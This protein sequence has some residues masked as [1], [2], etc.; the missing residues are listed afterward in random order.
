MDFGLIISNI[1]YW[2]VLVSGLAAM[3]LGGLW[4]SPAFLGNLWM[5]EAKLTEEDMKNA[6]PAKAMTSA[7][8]LTLIMAFNLAIFLSGPA[9]FIW[10]MTVGALAGIGWV[11]LSTGINYL[12]EGKSFKLFLING[13]YQA[14]SF[15]IMGGII[16]GWK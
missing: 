1:N 9:D 6:S 11:A 13:G 5:K 14:I 16:G 8:I 3:A 10:G 15:I 2:A 7:F 12:F 4:Y